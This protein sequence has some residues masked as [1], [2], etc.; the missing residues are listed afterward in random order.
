M[1]LHVGCRLRGEDV[2]GRF[3]EELEYRGV[4]ERGR[5]R[6]VDHYVRAGEGLGETS[7]GEGVD[8]GGRCRGDSF[9]A[10]GDEPGDQ[11]GT[12]Q[13]CTADDDDLHRE[14]PLLRLLRGRVRMDEYYGRFRAPWLASVQRP[15]RAPLREVRGHRP[16]TPLPMVDHRLTTGQ[17]VSR[18]E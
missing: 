9:V 16:G 5:I 4:L 2:A 8:A 12:D 18:P 10:V 17:P 11:L 15:S 3:L 1:M 13:A 14:L 6:H 7:A